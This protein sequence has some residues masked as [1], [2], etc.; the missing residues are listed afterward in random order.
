MTP[1]DL[2]DCETQGCDLEIGRDDLE[3]AA[4]VDVAAAGVVVAPGSD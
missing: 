2:L 4:G 1:C 3:R